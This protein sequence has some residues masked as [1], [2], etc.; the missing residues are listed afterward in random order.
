[1]KLTGQYQWTDYLHAQLLNMSPARGL[2][3][4]I[5]FLLIF[6]GVIF[7]AGF[8]DFENH[9]FRFELILPVLIPAGVYLL[10]RYVL[11]PSRTRDLFNQQ[12]ELSAP[13][14]M[15]I[16]DDGLKFSNEYGY[17][18]RPWANFA[19]WKEDGELLLLYFSDVV[20]TMIPKRM[21]T[22]PQSLEFIHAR[23]RENK[24]PAATGRSHGRRRL[25]SFLIYLALIIAIG[26][27]FYLGF[28]NGP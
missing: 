6:T 22:D 1:M 2:K 25:L 17:T 28:R 7:L 3:A 18:Q 19:K 5:Y 12:K 8:Y 4:L 15:E 23:L 16:S 27:M 10:I 26:A 11:L 9:A 14:E 24:I 13:F 21:F 20:F